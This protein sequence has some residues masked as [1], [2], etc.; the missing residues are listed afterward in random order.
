MLSAIRSS[1]AQNNVCSAVVSQS[2]D[3][4]CRGLVK[5]G[6]G[7]G[8]HGFLFSLPGKCSDE[9]QLAGLMDPAQPVQLLHMLLICLHQCYCSEGTEAPNWC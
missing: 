4:Q 3:L 1:I 6:F 8:Q 5:A 7:R 9:L 2:T